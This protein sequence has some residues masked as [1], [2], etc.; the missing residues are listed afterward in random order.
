MIK[1]CIKCK[2]QK[3]LFEFSKER[4]VKSGFK[5]ICKK[6]RNAYNREYRKTIKG[7]LKSRF[8][9]IKER[10]NNPKRKAYE[11]YGG[12]G[13]KC[14]F[15]SPDEFINYVINELQIDPRNLQIDRIDNDGHYEPGNI[16]FVTSKI[17][18]NNR[19]NS[20]S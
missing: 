9:N 10:C 11:R 8:R 2:E 4:R 5:P 1:Q 12:R 20:K 16:R 7:C 13:I 14:L 18:N 19:K 15:N 6:C 3:S 17:N